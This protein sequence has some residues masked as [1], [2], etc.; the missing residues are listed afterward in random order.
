MA[1]IFAIPRLF[2][3]FRCGLW[4]P[5]MAHTLL[6]MQV[7]VLIPFPHAKLPDCQ[8]NCILY[9]M[10]SSVLVVANST[11]HRSLKNPARCL[12]ALCP[13]ACCPFPCRPV[14]HRLHRQLQPDQTA[15]A[16]VGCRGVV[17]LSVIVGTGLGKGMIQR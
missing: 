14:L 7:L 13:I 8:W 3:G 1:H 10:L 16:S 2:K 11:G 5:P 4:H 12:F 17:L 6:H 15:Q 9:Q